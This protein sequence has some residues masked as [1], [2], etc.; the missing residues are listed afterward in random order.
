M[1]ALLSRQEFEPQSKTVTPSFVQ[2][3]NEKTPDGIVRYWDRSSDTM[4]H[5]EVN[6][7]SAFV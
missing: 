3:K 5:K 2:K 4:D 7:Q 6:K 1:F